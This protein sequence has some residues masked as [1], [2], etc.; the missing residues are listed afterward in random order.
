[1]RFLIEINADI[2][3]KISN[4]L[5]GIFYESDTRPIYKR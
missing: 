5:I 1:M 3:I 4:K 2:N